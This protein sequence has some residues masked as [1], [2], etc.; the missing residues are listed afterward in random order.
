MINGYD[1]IA[2]FNGLP[3]GDILEVIAPGFDPSTSN[4]NDFVQTRVEN[5]STIVSVDRDGA[6]NGAVF[7]DIAELQGVSTD[8]LGLL[9]NGSLSISD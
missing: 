5:G 6:L 4:I 9:N 7:I 8:V 1:V 2:D 3:G